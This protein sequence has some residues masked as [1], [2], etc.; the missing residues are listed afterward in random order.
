M[1]GLNFSK[2]V[3]LACVIPRLTITAFIGD[4]D[5]VVGNSDGVVEIGF[6]F[7]ASPFGEFYWELSA[8]GVVNGVD[9]FD[10]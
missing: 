5:C 1:G 9:G 3:V 8:K 6:D 7:G 10:D 2:A 4:Y